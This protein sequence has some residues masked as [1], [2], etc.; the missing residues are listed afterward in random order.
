MKKVIAIT[1]EMGSGKGTFIKILMSIAKPEMIGN[2]STS[3]FLRKAL[4][5]WGLMATR[6]NLQLLPEIMKASFGPDTF[7]D[8]MASEIDSQP[9]TIV[10]F[11]GPRFNA[12]ILYLKSKYELIL[13]YIEADLK[14]RYERIITR[15]EKQNESATSF[16]KFVEQHKGPTEST[17]PSLKD[18]AKVII[19]NQSSLEDLELQ[20]KNFYQQFLVDT[21][22]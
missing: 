13:V 20:T 10:I 5:L 12:D 4:S 1:G 3:G 22:K 21:L 11:D 2:V 15:G 9:Q 14:T 17:I 7:F 8:A 19:N 16:E 6:E 18:Q